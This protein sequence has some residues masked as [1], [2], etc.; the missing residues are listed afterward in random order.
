MAYAAVTT[1]LQS[2]EHLLQTN[3]YVILHKKEVVES[4]YGKV[5][6]LQIF[7]EDSEKMGYDH[8]IIKHLEWEIRDV[9]YKAGDI[10]DSELRNIYV[11]ES[12]KSQ[13]NL[14][15]GLQQVT[16]EINSIQ[17]KLT[18]ITKEKQNVIIPLPAG[19]FLPVGSSRRASNM[20]SHVVGLD[21]DLQRI[22][23][24]L[25]QFPPKLETIPIVGMGG[26]GKTTIARKLYD[27]PFIVLY[28]HVRLWVTVSQELNIRNLLLN[29]CQLTVDNEMTKEDLD[30]CLYK[31]LKGRRYLI[32]M[33]DVWTSDAWDAVK[34]IFPDDKNGSRI[35]V[36]SRQND[37]AFYVNP[38]NPHHINL[39]N[40]VDSWKLLCDK[41]FWEERCPTEV[42]DIGKKIAAKC[43]GLPLA[44]VVVA[45]YLLKI[46]RTRAYWE[47]VANSVASYVTG[48][49]QQCLDIIALS[50]NNLP[51]HLK[52]SFLYFGAFPE[53]SEIP[54]S[55]LI[56]LW[57][58]EGFL[59]QV[60][61]K[62]LEEVAD[63]CLVDLINRNLI[64]VR[65]RSYGRI[66]TCLIHD[67]LRDFCLRA[68]QKEKF[69]LV[70]N[71]YYDDFHEGENNLRRLSF[72][73]AYD[74]NNLST[75][76]L[77]S[78]F[79]YS[80]VSSFFSFSDKEFKLLR[81][82]DFLVSL[83]DIFPI[84]ILQL[85]NLRFLSLSTVVEL[86]SSISNLRNLQ[87]LILDCNPNLPSEIWKILQLRHLRFKAYSF[88]PD[89]VEA[90]NDGKS[91]LV[92]QNLQTLSKLS[93]SSCT[94]EVFASLPNLKKLGIYE[95]AEAHIT[96]KCWLGCI[97]PS[98]TLF[99]SVY[100]VGRKLSNISNIAQLLKLETL[101]LIFMKQFLEEQR[102]YPRV[103]QFPPNLKKLTL[104]FS[105]LPWENMNILS[106]LPNLEVLKLKNYA[107]IGPD[108]QFYEE[109]FGQLK[110]LLIY[111]TD[112][113]QW[114]ATSS[115]FPSLQHLVLSRCRSLIEVP[116]DFA[117]IP[118]LQTIELHDTNSAA[119]S[120]VKIQ[121][122]LESVGN[123]GLVVRIHSVF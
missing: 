110:Y 31:S 111:K 77:R 64:L 96:E 40:E 100:T 12:A 48:D 90:E 82:L 120:V 9:S 91:S 46:S 80:R 35:I 22:K 29:L 1:L 88:L 30:E 123:D 98:D 28:F 93:L 67:L 94:M 5:N 119:M 79:C 36:T 50:Y 78:L 87:T 44:I 105:Y 19:E 27:D 53:D 20:E 86:P 70:M 32:V 2:L 43:Q 21:N 83:F 62:S 109:G 60:E 71:H 13:R 16:E 117:E 6:F 118:S 14:F 84:E 69:L 75:S 73:S 114:K 15:Q 65:R 63:D 97:Y 92:L 4:L 34:S 37:V 7:L 8:E 11:S 23:D 89:P 113:V 81:V 54:A 49:P 18:K 38:E 116:L 108:W 39:L 66:K 68:A 103:D 101:K 85:S 106:V 3:P 102:W 33:D 61:G 10:I 41:V 72:H 56:K 104:S 59:K 99:T 51:H 74:F 58:A 122:E 42:E 76:H 57:M 55:R 17:K 107:F 52:A 24:R 115:Q 26:V 25:T 112:L 45:G 47:N 121:Q 95:T